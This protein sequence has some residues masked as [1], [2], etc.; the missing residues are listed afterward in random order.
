MHNQK[1]DAESLAITNQPKLMA[2][3]WVRVRTPPRCG[4]VFASHTFQGL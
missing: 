4:D 3:V 1:G 2:G